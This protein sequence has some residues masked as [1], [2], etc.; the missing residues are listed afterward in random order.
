VIYV[1]I[2]V[3]HCRDLKPDNLLLDEAGYLKITDV[4]LAK[5]LDDKVKAL[6]Y[7]QHLSSTSSRLHLPLL[8]YYLCATPGAVLP[9]PLV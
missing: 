4:G 9:S 6:K 7:I 3:L 5:P 1:I 2:L 8:I